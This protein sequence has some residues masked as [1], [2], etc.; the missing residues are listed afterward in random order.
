MSP[1]RVQAA[2]LEYALRTM[3]TSGVWAGLT[4]DE[5]GRLA[6]LRIEQLGDAHQEVA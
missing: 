3:P 4:A 2:C 1:A 5:I 6:D